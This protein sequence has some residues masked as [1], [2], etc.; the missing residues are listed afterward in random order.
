MTAPA[1]VAPQGFEGFASPDWY[2]QQFFS[3]FDAE[4]ASQAQEA[5]SEG[6][7]ALT[8]PVVK[9]AA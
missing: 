7:D 4:P 5:P 9:V 1:A 8:V 3:P 2:Q 6:L